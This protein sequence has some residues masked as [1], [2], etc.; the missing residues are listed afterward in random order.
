[1]WFIPVIWLLFSTLYKGDNITNLT[2]NPPLIHF[3]KFETLVGYGF[4]IYLRRIWF[5]FKN[6]HGSCE[7]D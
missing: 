6:K 5:D 1:M 3:D 4:Q 7:L 2:A